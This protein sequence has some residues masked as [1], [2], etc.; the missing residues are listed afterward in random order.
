MPSDALRIALISEHASP[1]G[2]RG[3]RGPGA[4]LDA[5]VRALVRRGHR[6][7]LLARR[8]SP[9]QPAL[10]EL[11]PGGPGPGRVRHAG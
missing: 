7:D 1:R 6:I 8:D 4:D 5:L 10:A 3:A 2:P 11:Q 9:A